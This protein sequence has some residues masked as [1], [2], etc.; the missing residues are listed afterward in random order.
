MQGKCEYVD[1]IKSGIYPIHR[2]N[3]LSRVT[4]KAV[5]LFDSLDGRLIPSSLRPQ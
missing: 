2:K 3:S 5:N 1:I 4:G